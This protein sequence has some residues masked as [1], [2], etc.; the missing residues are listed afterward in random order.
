MEII[1]I[2]LHKKKAY[3]DP[4]IDYEKLVVDRNA[5]RWLKALDKYGY[6]K[7]AAFEIKA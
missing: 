1:F 7:Q 3:V 6:L 2:L 4:G 5:P